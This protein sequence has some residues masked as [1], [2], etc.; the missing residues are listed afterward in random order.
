MTNLLIFLVLG[1]AFWLVSLCGRHGRWLAARLHCALTLLPPLWAA[2][3]RIFGLAGLVLAL[4]I[5]A[6]LVPALECNAAG[7]RRCV[8]IT[9]PVLA[10]ITPLVAASVW[11]GDRLK[12]RA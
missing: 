9:F 8:T 3:P 2:F 11:V 5:A 1:L 12:E 6:R 10:A 7:F 4:G